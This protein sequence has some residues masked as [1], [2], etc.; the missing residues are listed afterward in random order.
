MPKPSLKLCA[1][2]VFAAALLITLYLVRN[3][4]SQSEK[5]LDVSE[6]VFMKLLEMPDVSQYELGK[7]VCISNEENRFN[8]AFVKRFASRYPKLTLAAKKDSG[9]ATDPILPKCKI[10]LAVGEFHWLSSAVVD[11]DG[12]YY[13]SPLCGLGARF[14]VR[15]KAWGWQV[16]S[17]TPAYISLATSTVETSIATARTTPRLLR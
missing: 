5:E 11:V 4:D 7:G 9:I 13:C 10:L 16:E 1:S 3:K 12:S 6:A 17:M 15:R 2:T 8:S 14:E